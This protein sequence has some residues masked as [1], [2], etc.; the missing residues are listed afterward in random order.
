M[1]PKHGPSPRALAAG[2]RAGLERLADPAGAKQALT[3]FREPVEVLGISTPVL[4]RL[5]REAHRGAARA[6][7][8]PQAL[9]ACDL[10]LR[11]PRLEV[12]GAGLV[13]LGRFR[14]AFKPSMFRAVASW[15]SSNRCD[16]WA[17]VDALCGEVL[18][19]LL[20]MHP[21]LL[22]RTWRWTASRNRWMRRASLACL[23]RMARRGERLHYVYSVA[24]RLV[25]DE[26]DLVQ[27]ACGWLLREAGKTDA[28]RL[29]AVLRRHGPR[30]RRTALR[31]AIERFPPAKR[32]ELLAATRGTA[33]LSSPDR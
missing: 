25:S 21:A 24:L 27:K 30:I 3:Y 11:D 15:L 32:R 31:Y 23:V 33:R 10:L 19:P 13:L 4:R 2:L 9:E 7:G 20:A 22:A 12:K 6:W 5:V 29:E 8:L 17:T 16:S 14:R 1:R 28:R 26:E 18:S